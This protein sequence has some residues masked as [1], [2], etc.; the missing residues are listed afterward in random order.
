M[1]YLK[2]LNRKIGHKYKPLVI[3]ELGINH[4]GKFHIAKQII[5]KAK[6]AGDEV[7]KHQTHIAD[8][9]MSEE[10]KKIIPVHTSDNIFNIISKCSLSEEDENKL[11]SFVKKMKMIFLSTPFSREAADRLNKMN[12]PAFK[13]GSGECNN[14][15]LINHI[16]SKRKPI[17]LS[18]GMNDINSIK[19]AVKIIKSYRMNPFQLTPISFPIKCYYRLK[20]VLKSKITICSM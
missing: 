13:I 15:P 4:N 6:N 8:F 7:I 19:Y 1:S 16:A 17:I 11:Q 5:K 10:A 14:Y 18:S 20:L 2:I 3:V 9:E 12:V